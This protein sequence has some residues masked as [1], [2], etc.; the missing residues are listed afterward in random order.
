MSGYEKKLH[1]R[2]PEA[3][4]TGSTGVPAC[5]GSWL[6]QEASG[7][8]AHEVIGPDD[9][10]SLIDCQRCRRTRAFEEAPGAPGCPKVKVRPR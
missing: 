4:A 7:L 1:L 6:R 10:L 5:D 2:H 9:N 8:L 3:R